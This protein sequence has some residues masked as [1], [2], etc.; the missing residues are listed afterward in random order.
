M[1][2]KLT[3]EHWNF[4]FQHISVILLFG[5]LYYLAHMYL[6]YYDDSH[7]KKHGGLHKY[8]PSSGQY[9]PE[10]KEKG[11][12]ISL[13]DCIRFSLITQTTVGYGSLV[14]VHK[15]TETINV[16]QLLTIYGVIIISL[17]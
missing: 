8:N 7:S 6:I 16:L 17:F 14:P 1:F 15:L 4:F 11:V 3:Y 10:S 9:E 2:I 12:G 13:F 5:A